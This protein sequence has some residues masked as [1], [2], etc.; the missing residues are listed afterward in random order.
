[1]N[2]FSLLDFCKVRHLACNASMVSFLSQYIS[3]GCVADFGLK[4]VHDLL[5]GLLSTFF[6]CINDL[7]FQTI[8]DNLWMAR[9]WSVFC[10]TCLLIPWAFPNVS[11][12]GF[13]KVCH[14]G[15]FT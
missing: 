5:E 3:D 9:A 8:H 4:V 12:G 10:R 2:P 1:M 15:C 11:G 7:S 14:L 13:L 6:G